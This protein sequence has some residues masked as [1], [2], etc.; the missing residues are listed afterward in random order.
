MIQ[1]FAELPGAAEVAKM[2]LQSLLCCL[3]GVTAETD[4]VSATSGIAAVAKL[5]L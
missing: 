1:Q 2:T 3:A 4:N 5:A